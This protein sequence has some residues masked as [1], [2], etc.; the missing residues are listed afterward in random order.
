[1]REKKQRDDGDCSPKKPPVDDEITHLTKIRSEPSAKAL[2]AI[3]PSGKMPIP[4]IKMLYGREANYSGRGK[5]TLAD[6]SHVLGQYLPVNG[7]WR[8]DRM[9]SRPYVSQFSAD[10]SLLVVGLQGS[11]IK[12]YD[13]DKGCALHKDIVSRSLQWTI[14]D[15]S[16]SPDQRFLVYSSMSPVLHIVNV[17]TATTESHANINEIHENLVLSAD[18][19]DPFGIFSVKFSTDGRELVSGSS[20]NSIYM[21]D[22][23]A[24]Q[25]TTRILSHA[26]DVNTVTF[27]DETCQLMYS[28][29]NDSLC[30]VW[31]RRC[32]S[33]TAISK[34]VGVLLGHLQGITFID[35]RKDGRYF[36]SN[37]KDQT[38]KLWDIR[39]M[40][41]S[42]N[43][44][45]TKLW[46]DV[47]DYQLM[48]SPFEAR[49]LRHP[50]DMSL[51]TYQGHSV[52]RTLIRCYF[53]P[54]FSTGQK[55]IYTGSNDKCVH[56]FD[57]V[58]G[59][60]VAKLAFHNSTVRDCTWH[61]YHPMLISSS[62]D[63]LIARWEFSGNGPDPIMVTEQGGRNHASL[64]YAD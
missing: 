55:Y 22:L 33:A 29:S 1:M 23:E 31:D 14:T 17:G 8:V 50:K 24:N 48:E 3:H 39:K 56:I 6:C 30:K 26:S 21:Y 10:G 27:A 11:R 18:D 42:G 60:Q 61:P 63:C 53:S 46:F 38:I 16:L 45:V 43:W 15:T 44:P 12:I 9:D 25:V 37:S 47:G 5:F 62:W 54:E 2:K 41:S 57:I 64:L 32:L 28:G 49:N 4:T 40:Y 51:A 34:P 7:P 19:D 52:S 36:I 58:T 20:D 13:V 35:S 59:A